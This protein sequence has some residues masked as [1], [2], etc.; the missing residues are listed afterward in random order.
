[1]SLSS[2]ISRERFDALL[3][4]GILGNAAVQSGLFRAMISG[5]LAHAHLFTGPDG[6]GKKMVALALAKALVCANKSIDGAPCLKC[7]S[8]S[9]VAEG[10]HPDV[11]VFVRDK[12]TFSTEMMRE[13]IL[14]WAARRPREGKHKVGIL[15]DVEHLGTQSANAFLKTLEE[16]PQGTM[17]VLITSDPAATITTIRSRCQ[18]TA[19]QRLSPDEMDQLMKGT[20]GMALREAATE[21]AAR[22]GKGGGKAAAKT[23]TSRAG[24]GRKPAASKGK[25][26]GFMADDD[27][28][29]SMDFE[30]D[31][32]DAPA[33]V[34]TAP[35]QAFAL[36]F[37]QGSPGA[38]IASVREGY[39]DVRN[40]LLTRLQAGARELAKSMP[41][42][43]APAVSTG[44]S[45]PPPP[46]KPA[47]WG[48]TPSAA[49]QGPIEAGESLMALINREDEVTQEGARRRLG[50]S[51]G[52]AEGL[53]RD[54]L[55]S[56][57][58]ARVSLFNADVA[59]AIE[60]MPGRESGRPSPAAIQNGIER[61]AALRR[62]VTGNAS[63]KMVAAAMMLE[64][65][66]V[67]GA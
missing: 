13:V 42:T 47:G 44:R 8:C 39:L 15:D 28:H 34:L 37:A 50:V 61:M 55:V 1:M 20:L 40:L 66:G 10:V 3:D 57:S 65:E 49:D 24:A 45:I 59:R 52:I 38:A 53:L 22:L 58:G 32:D 29:D 26:A 51:L 46:A 43:P 6:V 36:S 2:P 16:P 64:L 11:R 18:S 21:A 9:M 63:P 41:K 56:A 48:A 17:W 31:H 62:A 54:M 7:R 60:S 14:D 19:F 23:A 33:D 4:P 30:G 12:S 5:R 25:N 35:Q 67:F 27:A